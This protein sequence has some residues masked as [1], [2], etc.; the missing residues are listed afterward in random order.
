MKSDDAAA[1]EIVVRRAKFT[2]DELIAILTAAEKPLRVLDWFI[3]TTLCPG[4]Y[5]R[6]RDVPYFTTNLHAAI[7]LIP[8]YWFWTMGLCELTGHVTIGPDYNGS[9]GER[10]HREFPSR[11]WHTGISYDLPPGDGVHRVCIAVCCA[12]LSVPDL[13]AAPPYHRT[14]IPDDAA[15]QR[16]EPSKVVQLWEYPDLGLRINCADGVYTLR[17]LLAGD[18]R[19]YC[20]SAQ[21]D[22]VSA[23]L[24]A[25]R[26]AYDWAWG[27][28]LAGLPQQRTALYEGRIKPDDIVDR[29]TLVNAVA[30]ARG[31]SS[32][33][34]N[35]REWIASTG[36]TLYLRNS[37]STA[38]HDSCDL[39]NPGVD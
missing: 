2:R 21:F 31:G 9:D 29:H 17:P 3:A 33:S 28:V 23:K 14:D 16:L 15:P 25:F 12:C 39:V 26:L 1:Y 32:L 20:A 34:L 7:S 35:D 37:L 19:V 11:E 22:D 13:T 24:R 4:K 6:E 36:E 5:K 27:V 38:L 18:E 10:L 8:P 30:A